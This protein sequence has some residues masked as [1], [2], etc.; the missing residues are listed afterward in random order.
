VNVP[1]V[2][3]VPDDAFLLDV[4]EP[5]EWAAG[6]APQASHVPLRQIPT[7]Y[8]EL[9]TDKPIVVVCRMGG[10][11]AQATAFLRDRGLDA[12]N[13]DGGMR[14]YAAAGGQLESSTGRPPAVI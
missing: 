7:R 9:P 10:R 12:Y 5:D 4:R 2:T 11:S 1:T 8:S 3:A 14:A 13:Y 6:R